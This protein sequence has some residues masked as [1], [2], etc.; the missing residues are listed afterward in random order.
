[1]TLAVGLILVLVFVVFAT[2]MSLER[3][4]ALLALPLMAVAFLI[5]ALA[6]DFAQPLFARAPARTDAAPAPRTRRF[7]TFRKTLNAHA[8]LLHDKATAAIAIA[9]RLAGADS[10]ATLAPA[11]A[12]A[13][14]RLSTLQHDLRARIDLLPDYPVQDKKF[15]ARLR[16]IS[17]AE[18]LHALATALDSP[19]DQPLRP[20]VAE[21]VDRL[22]AAAQPCRAQPTPVSWLF[23]ALRYCEEYLVRVLGHGA[24]RLSGTIIATIFGGMFAMYVKNLRIAE[25][26]VYWT[27]EF[28]GERPFVIT[29]AV[30]LATAGIFTSV[31][32]LGTVI[33]L[34]TII[35][36]ILRSVGLS[37]VVAA[38]TFLIAIA[39][40]GT[41]QPVNRRLWME[42]YGVSALQIDALI[43]TMLALYALLGLGWIW[44]GTRRGLLSSFCADA[45]DAP[46]HTRTIPAYLMAAPLLPVVLVYFARIEEITAF[47]I[48]IVYM[49]VCVARRTGA[50]RTLARALIE[51]AQAVMPPVLLMLG[52]GI[53]LTSLATRPVQ[54]NLQ[55]LLMRVVPDGRW[56]YIALFALGAPLALY[57]GP[58]NIWGM[59]LAVS[60]ILLATSGLPAPAIL[61]AIL[62]AGMLQG[63]SDPTN[64]A[65][66]WI[67]G[68]QGITVNKILRFTLVPV[69]IAAAIAVVIFGL[70][71]VGG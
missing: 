66:V 9:D 29:L 12:A 69:W 61:G 56:S 30:F 36:P 2:L 58:L 70:R 65:N 13:R 62:A 51:G 32:G 54:E 55:P 4:S 10:A 25:Q 68:F 17:I 5:I 21:T 28:A 19:A 63:I 53:L 1:M 27:A 47:T 50:T 45:A 40:G 48:G 38:G 52:I 33:M 35:L 43:L 7:E 22:R 60:A 42:F 37:P 46:K 39:M 18:H 23:A 71:Y 11:L 24:L 64:T 20:R 67:A 26:L 59:G 41:L 44:W 31:G 16:S 15:T 49:F 57:R 3:L 8:D 34:G 6:A 14:N